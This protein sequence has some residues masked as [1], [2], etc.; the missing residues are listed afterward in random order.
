MSPLCP[1]R[2]ERSCQ[3]IVFRPELP[4]KT[5]VRIV[6]AVVEAARRPGVGNLPRT[7]LSLVLLPNPS[8]LERC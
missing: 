2:L 6:R 4:S 8:L 5:L 1:I 3:Y 7:S